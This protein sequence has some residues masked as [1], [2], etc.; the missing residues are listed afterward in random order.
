MTCKTC[1]NWG[2]TI[3]ERREIFVYN[4]DIITIPCPDCKRLTWPNLGVNLP[5]G[6]A[7]AIGHGNCTKDLLWKL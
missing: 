7:W 1:I 5:A 2:S 6:A 3:D 4:M